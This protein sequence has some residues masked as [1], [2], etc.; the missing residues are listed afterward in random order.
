VTPEDTKLLQRL[1]KGPRAN[2]TEAD[3]RE[4]F[5]APLLRLL[6]Y[7]KDSDY[8]VNRESQHLLSKPFIMIGSKKQKL[9]YALLVRRKTFWILEAKRP[10]PREIP[11]EAIFQAH[12]YAMH[13]EVA[14]RYFGVCNGFLLALYDLRGL[15]DSYEPLLK[16]MAEE[17]PTRF[18][19]LYDVIGA[20]SL[21]KHLK[22][23]ALDDTRALLSAE[24]R[25]EQVARFA[26]DF[27]R[28]VRDVQPRVRENRQAVWSRKHDEYNRAFA[29]LAEQGKLQQIPRVLMQFAQNRAEL[30]TAHKQFMQK[31]EVMAPEVRRHQ[32]E[33]V[34][35][36]L[37]TIPSTQHKFNVLDLLLRLDLSPEISSK[38]R[39]FVRDAIRGFP[40]RPLARIQWKLEAALHRAIYKA[41]FAPPALLQAFQ[42]RVEEKRRTMLDEEIIWQNPSVWSE[43]NSWVRA[44]IDELWTRFS[45]AEVSLIEQVVA[46]LDQF[47]KTIEA[48]H[49]PEIRRRTASEGDLTWYADYDSPWDYMRSTLCGVLI[50]YPFVANALLDETDLTNLGNLLRD[51]SETYV[52]NHVDTLWLRVTCLRERI[53]VSAEFSPDLTTV[54]PLDRVATFLVNAHVHR[55]GR[56]ALQDGL[57]VSGSTGSGYAELDVRLDLDASMVVVDGGRS[58]R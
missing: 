33:Q 12:F 47:E 28:I 13:P 29:E 6:G 51:V 40:A 9:D 7:E 38:V 39:A 21:V 58:M 55:K 2:W 30:D 25:E 50:S 56:S 15:D 43:R 22:T 54:L 34:A 53:S 49:D 31:L 26:A 11:I 41:S 48:A 19:E 32:I 37:E 10:D 44:R 1:A 57:R 4:E 20:P 17:L 18:V 3:V 24:V 23:R 35:G 45:R 36:L 16:L 5:I 8:D 52:V 14:C 42:A 27:Q 46:E